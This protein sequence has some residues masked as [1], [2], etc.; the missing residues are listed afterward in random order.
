MAMGTRNTKRPSQS[1]PPSSPP[2]T[3]VFIASESDDES[4]DGGLTVEDYV[5]IM[6]EHS[7]DSDSQADAAD[8][9][10]DDDGDSSNE[11]VVPDNVEPS[12]HESSSDTMSE[13]DFPT[14]LTG[15]RERSASWDLNDSIHLGTVDVKGKSVAKRVVVT[16]NTGE[17]MENVDGKDQLGDDGDGADEPG[18]STA[19]E[20]GSREAADAI[21]SQTR[22]L[23]LDDAGVHGPVDSSEGDVADIFN[24]VKEGRSVTLTEKQKA[25]ELKKKAAEEE[26]KKKKKKK[27]A[28][29]AADASKK[30][31]KEQAKLELEKKDEVVLDEPFEREDGV[32]IRGKF[33][34]RLVILCGFGNDTECMYY[35]RNE[36]SKLAWSKEKPQFSR[37]LVKKQATRLRLMVLGQVTW[38]GMLPTRHPVDGLKYPKRPKVSVKCLRDGDLVY[39][40]NMLKQYSDSKDP[41][42]LQNMGVVTA[43]TDCGERKRGTDA[44]AGTAFKELYN[45]EKKY[46]PNK[47]GMET[48]RVNELMRGDIVMLEF[49]VARYY[50]KT[51][52]REQNIEPDWTSIRAYFRM[53]AVTL[54]MP[55][56]QQVAEPTTSKKAG[57]SRRRVGDVPMD[58]T[59]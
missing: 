11:W 4:V 59:L 7:S 10:K 24:A 55:G 38:N 3:K 58:T 46:A 8:A 53:E 47:Q 32:P 9:A 49:S 25:K 15:T 6:A 40:K 29:A 23:S 37:L 41:M 56:D 2:P 1:P 20:D 18:K 36:P 14:A 52:N 27:N 48:M 42:D 28:A 51:G 45:G 44:T 57:P 39:L 12:I 33:L 17:Y 50:D 31:E 13:S 43:Y 19:E 21:A 16:D 30:P 5:D 54:L 35:V 26:E 22:Q 34:R